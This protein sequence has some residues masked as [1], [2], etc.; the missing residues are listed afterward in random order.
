MK[1]ICYVSLRGSISTGKLDMALDF[2]NR[3]DPFETFEKHLK[4][5]L[6]W[7]DDPKKFIDELLLVNENE[8]LLDSIKSQLVPT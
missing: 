5:I 6:G 4:T 7:I 1:K 2:V 8:P 3:G